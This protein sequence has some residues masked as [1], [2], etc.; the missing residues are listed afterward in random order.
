M[1]KNSGIKYFTKGFASNKYVEYLYKYLCPI[2]C[3]F[4]ISIKNEQL[5]A[6]GM[7]P[8]KRIL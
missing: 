3:M 5:N 4:Y 2:H 1:L 8:S 6:P 7:Q